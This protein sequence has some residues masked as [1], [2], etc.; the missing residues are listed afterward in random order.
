M[1]GGVFGNKQDSAFLTVEVGVCVLFCFVFKFW[2]DSTTRF[3]STFSSTF[4][5]RY[6]SQPFRRPPIP[7]CCQPWTGLRLIPSWNSSRE[8]W[9]SQQSRSTPA[10]WRKSSWT[11]HSLHCWRSISLTLLGK[12]FCNVIDFYIYNILENVFRFLT[13]VLVIRHFHVFHLGN[14]L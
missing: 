1:Y 5:S 3:L 12:M 2:R 6:S 4:L 9:A 7:W 13:I 8:S 14:F 11:A 10:P